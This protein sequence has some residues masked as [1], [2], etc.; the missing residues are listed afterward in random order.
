MP[1]LSLFLSVNLIFFVIQGLSGLNVLSIPLRAH[2]E[3]QWYSPLART[4]VERRLAATGLPPERFADRFEAEEQTL[5]KASVIT[6]VPLFAMVA[7]ALMPRERQ[8]YRIQLVF[9]LHLYAF[10]LLFLT[11]FFPPLSVAWRLA[12]ALDT[13]ISALTLDA[14]ATWIEVIALAAYLGLALRRAFAISIFRTAVAMTVLTT[15]VGALLYLQ[16]MV[17]FMLTAWTIRPLT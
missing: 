13:S 15:T 6:M 5:A 14:F 16:R 1:P 7:A 10:L 12:R 9:G 17:V 8:R 2:L 11:L 4:V 3:S